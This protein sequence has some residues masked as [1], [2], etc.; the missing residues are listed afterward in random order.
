MVKKLFPLMLAVF[1]LIGIFPLTVLAAF[2]DLAFTLEPGST[3]SKTKLLIE[4]AAYNKA[5]HTLQMNN[6]T[7]PS[8]YSQGTS[9]TGIG[10]TVT[11]GTEFTLPVRIGTYINLFEVDASK[12]LVN[13]GSI[14]ITNAH[15]PAPTPGT[16]AIGGGVEKITVSSYQ[17]VE[18]C[19]LYLVP[20]SLYS[21][22]G[23]AIDISNS[24]VREITADG[25]ISVAAG[26]YKLY[27]VYIGS[28]TSGNHG[29]YY[30]G[31]EVTVTAA[32]A[33]PAE[34]NAWATL[35]TKSIFVRLSQGGF[36]AVQDK[37]HWLLGGDGA[38]GNSIVGVTFTDNTEVQITLTND[39][40]A[41]DPLTITA[42]QD[43]FADGTAP[44]SSPLTVRLDS[45]QTYV[46]TIDEV[47]YPSLKSA[48]DFAL[49]PAVDDK[50]IV[51]VADITYSEPIVVEEKT[52]TFNLNGFNLLVDSSGTI[53]GDW[54][55]ASALKV[56]NGSINY[57]GEGRFTVCG[58][59]RG[60]EAINGGRARV[61]EILIKNPGQP[62]PQHYYVYGAH[63]RYENN[64]GE[65]SQITVAG[66]IKTL[67]GNFCDYAIGALA[68]QD[69]TVTVGG[70]IF[71][72]GENV[73][74]LA[75]GSMNDG[76][77]TASAG[78]VTVTGES[79]TGVK[80][81]GESTAT[82]NG[83]VSATG[84]YAVGVE[85]GI[86]EDGSGGTVIVK[87]DVAASGADSIG[88]TCF[89]S[90]AGPAKSTVTVE[91][92]VSGQDYLSIDNIAREKDD[93]DSVSG[94]YWIY[95]GQ[96]ESV[97]KVKDPDGGTPAGTAPSIG[98]D[99]LPGGT[100]GAAY[101]Q[102]LAA[103]GDTPITWTKESGNLPDG[104]A[105]SSGGLISGTP[106]TAG[107]F[108]FTVQAAN[109]TGSDTQALSITIAALPATHALTVSAGAGGSVSGTASGNYGQGHSVSVTANPASGCHFEN[110][111]V[112][113]VTLSSD[114]A[115]PAT[116]TMPANAVT[117]TANFEADGGAAPSFT[118]TQAGL[119]YGQSPNPTTGNLPAGVTLTWSYSGVQ[120]DGSSYGPTAVNPTAAGTYTVTATATPPSDPSV[121]ASTSFT[122][123]PK[124]L[125]LG[126]MSVATKAYDGTVAATLSGTPELKGLINNDNVSANLSAAT[127][128]FTTAAVGQNKD[129][130]VTGLALAG[131]K[132]FNYTLPASLSLVGEIKALSGG[133]S[134]GSGGGGGGAQQPV[135]PPA[136]PGT[137]VTVT[138]ASLSYISG[139]DRVETSVAISRQGWTSADTVILAPGGQNNLI[140]ALAVAPLAGQ[141]N[142]PILLCVG[143]LDP[144]VVAEIERLG[145]KKVYTVGALSG[146]VIEALKAALP[147]VAV[148]VLRGANRF[149]TAALINAKVLNPKG[150]F[151]VG[152]N[153]IA[154]AVS[155]ASFAAAHGYLIQIAQPDGTLATDRYPL[156]T[157]HQPDGT[158]A[159][160]HYPL[161]TDHYI[162]GGP[163]LV[164]DVTGATR[165]FGPDRYATNKAI[166][167]ALTF[168]YTNIYTA[169]G[170]T[171][172]DALTG[173]A[174]AARTRAAIVL[175][176]AGDPSGVDFGGITTE[177]RVYAF[178]GA[179]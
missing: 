114:T 14:Q 170:A 45:P 146:A 153:A 102:T 154:D 169:D 134:G 100:A 121:S 37:A 113:G 38:S 13:R 133:G 21:A 68:G 6:T 60:V 176:P 57:T 124:A 44:F 150:T 129:V 22:G 120:G 54:F 107:T 177:T 49:A 96:Y 160:D 52:L 30:E 165:L 171:L 64:E 20:A 93:K 85:A 105:L 83:A 34:G 145:A 111:T 115:N 173:S 168:E 167:E 127:A 110:W 67:N 28:F 90:A 116:F 94:G 62:Y 172:V 41:L 75:A 5:N 36:K 61:S 140:D 78:N 130:T 101:S 15:L 63:A 26:T 163:T 144:A 109:G 39:I 77:G 48:L 12:N 9:M 99:S 152:Y 112:D 8:T 95:N 135:V 82:V 1:V 106:T 117:L 155:A 87:S 159:T 137:P 53:T 72:A 71:L 84:A 104:L 32:A 51:L 141:E 59:R 86:A 161:P 10:V 119:T 76:N 142:A 27:T 157:D 103:T 143:G 132:A 74:G 40:N 128:V 80:A 35:Y 24:G 4:D 16:T 81:A 118:L 3:V 162:L 178:G 47:A 25:D 122:I 70:D 55:T 123:A 126:G 108:N 50:T 151:I 43:A 33:I 42:T 7:A 92:T 69:S 56:D 131:A 136:A 46:C 66:D 175:T 73:I 18:N 138:K 179:R 89:S 79:A 23:G 147:N 98:T 125:T 58:E 166:R 31:S 17:A 29:A 88:V 11:S 158:L 174:L 149:E 139:A 164:G 2:P 97:V 65:G 91:G 19:G 156:P 148:E